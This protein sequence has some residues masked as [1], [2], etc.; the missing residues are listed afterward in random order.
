M[1]RYPKKIPAESG[2]MQSRL[3]DF[4]LHYGSRCIIN[5]R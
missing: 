2:K 3:S 5:E 1:P 4:M